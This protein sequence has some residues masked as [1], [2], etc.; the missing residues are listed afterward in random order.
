MDPDQQASDEINT[1][2]K[3]PLYNFEKVM[4]TMCFL[5]QIL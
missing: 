3:R 1:V 5:G 4:H 2:L